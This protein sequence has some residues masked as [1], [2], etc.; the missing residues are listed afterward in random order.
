MYSNLPNK[1]ILL[2]GMEKCYWLMVL[3]K[4]GM[5]NSNVNSTLIQ[6]DITKLSLA[7]GFMWFPE[8]KNVLL[9]L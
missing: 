5:I 2:S 8:I 9:T 1:I 7:V 3:I 6:K 4:L